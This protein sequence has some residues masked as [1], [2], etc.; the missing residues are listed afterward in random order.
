MVARVAILLLLA[1]SKSIWWILEQPRGS[2]LEH[3]PL[4][5]QVFARIRTWR[6]HI[7]MGDYAAD[8]DKGTWLYSSTFIQIFSAKNGLDGSECGQGFVPSF[9]NIYFEIH[10]S[11]P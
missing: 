6:Q 11:N 7:R 9:R 1:S 10:H 4:M 2:L 8:T 3:R 5:E